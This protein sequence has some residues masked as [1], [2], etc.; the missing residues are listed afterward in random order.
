MPLTAGTKLGPYEIL[1]PIGAGGMGE[2]HR[3]RDSRLGRDVAIKVSRENFSERFEREARVIAQLNHPHICTIH[4]VGPNYLV[5]ELV[6]G[7][8]LAARL[9]KGPLPLDRVFYYGAQIAAALAAAH[10]KGVIHRDLKPANI[11]IAKSGIKVLD[12]GLAKSA[13]D[14]TITMENVVVGTPGYMS[15]E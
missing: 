8:T 5:M 10:A 13:I 4:D 9:K 7:E 15:P 2:V 11:I 12:F 14:E 3:A 6:E 1:S